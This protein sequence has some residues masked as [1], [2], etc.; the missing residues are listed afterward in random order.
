MCKGNLMNE[1]TLFFVRIEYIFT[2]IRTNLIIL[3]RKMIN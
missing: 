2:Q 1:R 3:D